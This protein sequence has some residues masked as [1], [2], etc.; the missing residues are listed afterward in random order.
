M[1]LQKLWDGLQA[2]VTT[3]STLTAVLVYLLLNVIEISPVKVQP[4]SWLFKGLKTALVGTLEARVT[5]M[6]S[7]N[8]LE[9]AKIARARIQRFSDECYNGVRHSQQH[10][11]QV[12]DDIKSYESYCKDHPDFENHKTVEAVSIIKDTYHRC[13]QNHSFL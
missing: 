1:T 7:K 6:E 5:A 13:M 8:D 9:V 2:A 3:H 10:F 12:F 11:E 4:L